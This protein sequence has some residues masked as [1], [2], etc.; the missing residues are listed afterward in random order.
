VSSLE[1][2]IN[3]EHGNADVEA[4]R[5]AV[6][7]VGAAE[8][9]QVGEVSVTLLSD[10]DIQEINRTYLDRDRPTDVI[11]FSLGDDLA[12]LGDVYIGAEEAVRQAEELGIAV[13]EEVVRLTVHGMLHVLGHDHPEGPERTESAMFRRQEELLREI[14]AD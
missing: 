11:A 12:I 14:L 2:T 1:V 5:R 10:E 3:V 9:R 13:S 7:H 8:G 4:L 6:L